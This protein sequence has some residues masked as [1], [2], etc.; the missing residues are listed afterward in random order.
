MFKCDRGDVE[1]SRR[2]FTEGSL[3][4]DGVH[5]T[6]RAACRKVVEKK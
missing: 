6:G 3:T 1:V 4:R 2:P 5:A